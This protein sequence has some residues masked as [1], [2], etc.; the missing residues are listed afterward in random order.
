MLTLAALQA[1]KEKTR[2]QIAADYDASKISSLR[3]SHYFKIL[4]EDLAHQVDIAL[5]HLRSAKTLQDYEAALEALLDYREQCR[6]YM[7][8]VLSADTFPEMRQES[9]PSHK[10]PFLGLHGIM[11]KVLRDHAA[12]PQ[13]LPEAPAIASASVVPDLALRG[14][15]G[16]YF[17]K[18]DDDKNVDAP[19][20]RA[21][22]SFNR[23]SWVIDMA[24]QLRW[25]SGRQVADLFGKDS[26]LQAMMFVVLRVLYPYIKINFQPI[27]KKYIFDEQGFRVDPDGKSLESL[28]RD[29]ALLSFVS[30]EVGDAGRMPYWRANFE[31]ALKKKNPRDFFLKR[32]ADQYRALAC[33]YVAS[34]QQGQLKI[35]ERARAWEKSLPEGMPRFVDLIAQEEHLLKSLLPAPSSG[36]NAYAHYVELDARMKSAMVAYYQLEKSKQD[37]NSQKDLL[38]ANDALLQAYGFLEAS[39]RQK[40]FEA[41]LAQQNQAL[42]VVEYTR[43]AEEEI[44]RA[45]QPLRRGTVVFE[46]PEWLPEQ[47]ADLS[48]SES[49]SELRQT[50]VHFRP[51]RSVVVEPEL[52]LDEASD[53]EKR[54]VDID[55]MHSR[56]TLLRDQVEQA[57]DINAIED[58]PDL[59]G[60]V[61]RSDSSISSK[62]EQEEIFF[63]EITSHQ[64]KNAAE[65]AGKKSVKALEEEKYQEFYNTISEFVSGLKK[66]SKKESF[67][68]DE[69]ASH[70][71]RLESLNHCKEQCLEYQNKDK[72]RWKA[73]LADID[74]LSKPIASRVLPRSFVPDVVGPPKEGHHSRL[75]VSI[76]RPFIAPEMSHQQGYVRSKHSA[77]YFYVAPLQTS[78][79][80]YDQLNKWPPLDHEAIKWVDLRTVVSMVEHGVQQ[81]YPEYHVSGKNKLMKAM[82]YAVL[83][84]R[85]PASQHKKIHTNDLDFHH[86]YRMDAHG[87]R[88]DAHGKTL[89]ELVPDMQLF[90]SVELNQFLLMPSTPQASVALLEFKEQK[91]KSLAGLV[92]EFSKPS[93]VA[94]A[95]DLVK[96]LTT[97]AE[98]L[99]KELKSQGDLPA[100]ESLVF[101]AKSVRAQTPEEKH[102]LAEEQEKSIE[103]LEHEEEAA[104][105][106]LAEAMPVEVMSRRGGQEAVTEVSESP[107]E[108][109]EK[110]YEKSQADLQGARGKLNGAQKVLNA[111]V[112][113]GEASEE[114]LRK[115]LKARIDRELNKMPA[116]R[117]LLDFKLPGL[118]QGEGQDQEL[119]LMSTQNINFQSLQR[120]LDGLMDDLYLNEAEK[121]CAGR[122]IE[123]LKI[124]YRNQL[125]CNIRI[126]QQAQ[127]EVECQQLRAL[128]SAH[129]LAFKKLD[130]AKASLERL[131]E[132]AGERE[133]EADNR[134]LDR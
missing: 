46:R 124:F 14:F 31:N 119:Q 74:S 33:L 98:A 49:E 87:F 42:S 130:Q 73:L 129:I 65:K 22:K 41:G 109:I 92:A 131:R 90:L 105:V 52:D 18:C 97:Q 7:E 117:L 99:E 59:D 77:Q 104:R 82:M 96:E 108:K 25:S 58:A 13:K 132:S 61:S 43:L 8:Y 45:T 44:A 121:S 72:K 17:L 115:K 28:S 15:G 106:K 19:L 81:R 64:E 71:K 116:V 51:G 11:T 48:D 88:E 78:Y 24:R 110:A 114:S 50:P 107:Q 5:D 57:I 111:W 66:D 94:T 3:R 21:E 93:A 134:H 83:K 26:E 60:F 55:E 102:L 86:R 76:T 126:I 35:V 62:K 34:N 122:Y 12:H 125:G 10:A 89:N 69:W 113:I 91:Y 53:R 2:G 16:H 30:V 67:F 84:A 112:S 32:S 85:L 38:A 1:A 79:D 133:G 4:S 56:S 36:I 100:F 63:P 103:T 68:A 54:A 70:Q 39:D 95:P 6:F 9:W 127:C 27:V 123:L 29:C 75:D 23:L 37:H 118:G 120:N 80:R 47:Q 20:P 128:N 101:E 40:L